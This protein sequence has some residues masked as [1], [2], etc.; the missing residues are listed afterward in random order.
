[1][2]FS[3]YTI[4]KNKWLELLGRGKQLLLYS[5]A[6]WLDCS[7]GTIDGK[8]KSLLQ[9]CFGKDAEILFCPFWGQIFLGSLF[10]TSDLL[11]SMQKE[12][13]GKGRNLYYLLYWSKVLRQFVW[14][15]SVHIMWECAALCK[16]MEKVKKNQ[17]CL[18][19]NLSI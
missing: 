18:E 13:Q 19:W 16:I 17:W 10:S 2:C 12:S 11:A 1:M 15:F 6:L 9:G 3:A 8:E 4:F 14:L 5:S 7:H